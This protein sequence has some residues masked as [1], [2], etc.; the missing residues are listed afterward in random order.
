MNSVTSTVLRMVAVSPSAAIL[1]ERAGAG[2]S[3]AN[4]PVSAVT[5]GLSNMNLLRD[6]LVMRQVEEGEGNGRRVCLKIFLSYFLQG[7]VVSDII[8]RTLYGS[9]G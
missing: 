2:T 3:T 4:T 1:I 5:G 6:G 9:C 7:G 8:W